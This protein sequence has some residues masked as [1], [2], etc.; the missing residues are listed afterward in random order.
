MVSK[1]DTA[2]AIAKQKI[3]ETEPKE[4]G[5][6]V[7][8][9]TREKSQGAAPV[10]SANNASG[11]MPSRNVSETTP[12]SGNDL[13]ALYRKKYFDINDEM[14]VKEF[15]KVIIEI[16]RLYSANGKDPRPALLD[17]KT[18]TEVLAQWSINLEKTKRQQILYKF[19]KA[20]TKNTDLKYAEGSP[21]MRLF[22]IID[23][24]DRN[25]LTPSPI[26]V[27]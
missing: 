13:S 18:K 15:E 1:I 25:M 16:E 26:L 4:K 3:K 17:A 9:K 23:N 6:Y 2:N 5:K 22:D 11:N 27:K 24:Y 8:N 20:V 10:I 7:G 19:A 14:N 12:V 21:L